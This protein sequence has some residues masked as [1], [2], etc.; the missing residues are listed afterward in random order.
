M[1]AVIPSIRPVHSPKSKPL[2]P[3]LYQQDLVLRLLNKSR[4]LSRR[5]RSLLTEAP[6]RQESCAIHRSL[7]ERLVVKSGGETG[8]VTDRVS[9]RPVRGVTHSRGYSYTNVGI[10]VTY[11]HL[12]KASAARVIKSLATSLRQVT[13]HQRPL[14]LKSLSLS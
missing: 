6:K 3:T 12:K 5:H 14:H 1:R 4:E 2:K 11:D 8:P 7:N 9:N 10:S 13:S